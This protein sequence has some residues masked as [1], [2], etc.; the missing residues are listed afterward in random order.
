M[1]IHQILCITFLLFPIKSAFSQADSIDILEHYIRESIENNLLLKQKKVDWQIASLKLQAAK[2][3]FYPELSFNARYTVAD[4]GRIID[5]P[6]GDLLNPVYSTLNALLNDNQFPSIGNESFP[7]Y[8]P[9]EHE[10]KIRLVQP[11]L[12]TD[13][14]Y[15]RKIQSHNLN[16]IAADIN[17]YK[18]KLVC[19]V[20]DAYYNHLQTLEL[21]KLLIS[22]RAVIEENIRVT[23]HLYENDMLS[24]DIVLRAE[25]ERKALEENIVR[26]EGGVEVSKAW[27]NFLLNRDFQTEILTMENDVPHV[28]ASVYPI[29]SEAVEKR[30]EII[31]LKELT[32]LAANNRKMNARAGIPEV[33]AV[34][35]YG[36]QGEKYIFGKDDD[37]V[38]A[39]VVLK[40]DLFTGFRNR[41]ES[42][43]AALQEDVSYTRLEEARNQLRL[44]IINSWYDMQTAAKSLNASEATRETSAE[45][46]RMVRK[47]YEQN[48]ASLLELIDA[49]TNLTQSQQNTIINRFELMKKQA[50]FERVI[51]AYS[52]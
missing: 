8:R 44:E 37:Y 41:S 49:R 52:F 13:I 5:F 11:L 23:N 34:V 26:A 12:N 36:F 17:S 10:T 15:N 42:E 47:R 1:K 22:T 21:L 46:F 2:G 14:Y 29:L 39:S 43:V 9:H 24:Y 18:R 35:D 3:L 27:F 50:A 51:A 45:V 32:E 30:E 38:L 48:Q 31:Q 40:W 6:V 4:G 7:F 33:A 16:I 20:K 25:S 19:E 28:T